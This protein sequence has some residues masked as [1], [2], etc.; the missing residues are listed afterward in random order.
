[1][2]FQVLSLVH[3]EIYL[4]GFFFARNSLQ[5]TLDYEKYFFYNFSQFVNTKLNLDMGT[6]GN[7][8]EEHMAW[9]DFFKLYDEFRLVY[10]RNAN[11]FSSEV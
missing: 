8:L 4:W 11:Q 1:M 6:W 7:N 9:E 5:V 3:L 10:K 2:F